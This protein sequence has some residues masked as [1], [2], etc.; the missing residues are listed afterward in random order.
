MTR[1]AGMSDDC[2]N[3]ADGRLSRLGLVPFVAFHHFRGEHLAL[4]WL[5]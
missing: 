5:R 1:L 2:A 3:V 4:H